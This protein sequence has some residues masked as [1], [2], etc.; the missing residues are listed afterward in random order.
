[1]DELRGDLG[2]LLTNSYNS[3]NDAKH[4]L[5]KKGYK[6]DNDL[7]TMQSKIFINE[8]DEPI[9]VHRGSVTLND[10]IDDAKIALG[11]DKK[12]IKRVE[13]A[14]NL[15]E[16]L[17]EKYKKPVHNVGHS[18]GGYIAENANGN[19]NIITYNKASGLGD[20]FT[21]KNKKRQLDVFANGDVASIIPQ[22]TQ[23]S[24]KEFITVKRSS[25]FKPIRIK[26][27]HSTSNLF[28]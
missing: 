7:S 19:G 4:N 24:N 16:L 6:Y 25:I 17:K 14:K 23:N 12:N 18:L 2:E 3:Q 27:A 8:I 26:N 13:D 28:H 21:K 22:S 20:L 1:M 11:F 15:N 9:V 5:E 10:W